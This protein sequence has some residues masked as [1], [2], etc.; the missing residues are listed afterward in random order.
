MVVMFAFVVGAQSLWKL[1]AH[2][3]PSL[4]ITGTTR[5]GTEFLYDVLR[6]CH[7]DFL[8]RNRKGNFSPMERKFDV[9][10]RAKRYL[11]DSYKYPCIAQL[12][13]NLMKCPVGV[14]APSKE[15]QH[16]GMWLSMCAKEKKTM[17]KN[18]LLPIEV[19][20]YT[21]DANPYFLRD[22]GTAMDVLIRLNYGNDQCVPSTI[23]K[24]PFTAQWDAILSN[25][26]YT[27]M[28]KNRSPL[29]ITVLRSPLEHCKSFYSSFVL[30]DVYSRNI[31]IE[32][33][34]AILLEKMQEQKLQDTF[35]TPISAD[36][37]LSRDPFESPQ[38]LTKVMLLETVLV[39]E[40][41]LL[42]RER[43]LAKFLFKIDKLV[44]D[45]LEII[46]KTSTVGT[47]HPTLQEGELELLHSTKAEFIHL[48]ATFANVWTKYFETKYP[49]VAFSTQGLLLDCLYL[50]QLLQLIFPPIAVDL[51]SRAPL[52][53]GKNNVMNSSSILQ[54]PLLIMQSEYLQH[55]ESA[56]VHDMLSFLH[57][58]SAEAV[59]S[60]LERGIDYST[61]ISNEK[62]KVNHIHQ[63]YKIW[64]KKK[65]LMKDGKNKL[66]NS[67]VGA[68]DVRNGS[69]GYMS[70]SPSTE[71][72]LKD[73]FGVRNNQLVRCL[74]HFQQQVNHVRIVP[75]TALD[76]NVWWP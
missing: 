65:A 4:V 11:W 35:N 39:E 63:M 50:P 73:F 8:A 56:A 44:D 30:S 47:L 74:R 6:K 76:R 46:E 53:S 58:L 2:A 41:D 14:Q 70:I 45:L 28:Q 1:D 18:F 26:K 75:P 51:P 72:R 64:R 15:P 61:L 36:H 67:H 60:Q 32:K 5:S 23:P 48:Q 10:S 20:K 3:T 69:A 68:Y 9:V 66:D 54:W 52:G 62:K 25:D 38:E 33:R 55:N 71:Q 59:E 21:L 31:I 24:D 12:M 27:V 7:P 17:N 34:N 16:C 40:L 22:S 42:T 19:P 13:N 29:L 57:P 37:L 49:G 43:I